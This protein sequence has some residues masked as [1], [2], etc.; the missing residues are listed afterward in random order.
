[1]D[2]PQE[3]E[4]DVPVGGMIHRLGIEGSGAGRTGRQLMESL[5]LGEGSR[6][7]D[8][9]VSLTFYPSV[10]VGTEHTG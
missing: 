1:M 8:L 10:S 6:V 7:I 4:D 2:P 9:H 5:G 3:G